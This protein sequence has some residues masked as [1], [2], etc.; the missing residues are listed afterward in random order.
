MNM[1]STLGFEYLIGVL[2]RIKVFQ[3][4]T[5]YDWASRS[6]HFR[7]IMSYLTFVVK[8]SVPVLGL[9]HTED[10]GTTIP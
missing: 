4:V 7:V 10:E 9:L 6:Q 8:Q 1:L 2:L 5:Q 3:S